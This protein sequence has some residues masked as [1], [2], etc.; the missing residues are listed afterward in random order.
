[1]AIETNQAESETSALGT[2]A[3]AHLVIPEPKRPGDLPESST[4]C[5]IPPEVPSELREAPSANIVSSSNNSSKSGFYMVENVTDGKFGFPRSPASHEVESVQ[6]NVGTADIGGIG[7]NQQIDAG[8]ANVNGLSISESLCPKKENISAEDAR[9]SNPDLDPSTSE[10]ILSSSSAPQNLKTE[11]NPSMIPTAVI[12]IKSEH[13]AGVGESVISANLS[14]ER[15]LSSSP[16]VK[17]ESSH[18]QGGDDKHSLNIKQEHKDGSAPQL[19]YMHFGSGINMQHRPLLGELN[20]P[21]TRMPSGVTTEED[22]GGHPLIKIKDEKSLLSPVE[23]LKASVGTVGGEH[24]NNGSLSGDSG[25]CLSGVSVCSKSSAQ[26][27]SAPAS[28]PLNAPMAGSMHFHHVHGHSGFAVPVPKASPHALH[29]ILQHTHTSVSSSASGSADAVISSSSIPGPAPG[30]SPMGLGPGLPPPLSSSH[31]LPLRDDP[32]H[33]SDSMYSSS[34]ARFY[35]HPM[36]AL[37][38]HLVTS[39]GHDGKQEMA[40]N[41]LQSLR[42]VK[43]PGYPAFESSAASASAVP[44]SSSGTPLISPYSTSSQDRPRRES[45]ESSENDGRERSEQRDRERAR[46]RESD[47]DRNR[48]RERERDHEARDREK[49]RERQSKSSP[50]LDQK[51]VP[52][53]LIVPPGGNAVPSGMAAATMTTPS[54]PQGPISHANIHLPPGPGAPFA[55]GA[56]H[57]HPH[58]HPH[59]HP[60]PLYH[61]YPYGPYFTPYPFPHYAS[62][63]QAGLV[64]SRGGT[65]LISGPRPPSPSANSSNASHGQLNQPSPQATKLSEPSH[66]HS[67]HHTSSKSSTSKH[68]SSSSRDSGSVAVIPGVHH[69][70]RTHGSSS[71]N[72]HIEADMDIVHQEADEPDENPSPHGVPRGPSPEPKVEDSECHRSQSAIFLRHWN[73]GDFNSCARTDLTF[74]P[75]PESKLARKREERLRKQAEREREERERAAQARKQMATPDSKRETPKPG[76]SVNS[77]LAPP[78]MVEQ[79]M[80]NHQYDRFTPR[81]GFADTPALRQLSEYARPH[82]GFSPGAGL[83]PGPSGMLPPHPLEQMLGPSYQMGLY[84]PGARERLE[85]EAFEK[86]EREIREIRERELSDRLKEEFLRGVPQNQ[87]HQPGAPAG[88]GSAAP[89]MPNPLDPHWLDVHRRFGPMGPS[90]PTIGSLHQSS[91]G[92]YPSAGPPSALSPLERERLERLGEQ[93]HQLIREMRWVNFKPVHVGVVGS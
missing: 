46:E 89:R 78:A 28:L 33:L 11:G 39:A 14:H 17:L 50:G 88:P 36:M 82:T 31:P 75:V 24:G 93:L 67:H 86:R 92:L 2:A 57:P 43:V 16:T 15:P 20:V 7:M 87:S 25:A 4:L 6:V 54:G 90:G 1:M 5:S 3:A 66:S 77:G 23:D 19:P 76:S 47:R 26:N 8:S 29:S 13:L 63:P 79:S 45:A 21:V 55:A 41:P 34:M 81:P 72:S 12:D 56:F 61:H 52:G 27:P 42:E 49:D 74:K 44:S 65:H 18:A 69:G 71:Q 30:P 85:I 58:G 9:S 80:V 64:P 60:H 38:D 51:M 83:R 40:P 35:P 10:S 37:P 73:R 70:S 62:P 53:G 68:S 32:N 91:F 48:E 59:A 22:R 84:G